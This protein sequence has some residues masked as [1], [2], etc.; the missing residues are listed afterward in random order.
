MIQT[1]IG[2]CLPYQ[3][4]YV[5]SPYKLQVPSNVQFLPIRNRVFLN[6]LAAT[7]QF[8]FYIIGNANRSDEH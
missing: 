2:T 7:V 8:V 3:V 4:P 5:C 1:F 6:I